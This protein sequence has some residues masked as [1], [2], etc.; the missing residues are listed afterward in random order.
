MTENTVAT[1]INSLQQ[2]NLEREKELA[3]KYWRDENFKITYQGEKLTL[4]EIYDREIEYAKKHFESAKE[5]ANKIP[6]GKFVLFVNS[7]KKGTTHYD[8]INTIDKDRLERMNEAETGDKNTHPDNFQAAN[9]RYSLGFDKNSEKFKE[10]KSYEDIPENLDLTHCVGIVY[11]GSEINVLEEKD[12]TRIK[13]TENVK[14]IMQIA[15]EASI[16]ELGICFGGQLLS[17][18]KGADIQW[19]KDEKGNLVRVVGIKEIELTEEAKN[20]PLVARLE[21]ILVAQN[22]GQEINKESI[23]KVGGII[24]AVSKTGA[25]EIVRFGDKI[26]VL[27]FH[28]EVGLARVDVAMSIGKNP[29]NPEETFKNSIHQIKEAI[30]TGFMEIVVNNL[31]PKK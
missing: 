16:P 17:N 14:H 8:G 21:N 7:A 6:D 2:N 12:G 18:T 15:K 3:N 29:S 1:I 24:L 25:P 4:K 9:M 23:E 31:P 22:H 5:I 20:D 30:M 11:S 28:P 26:Y 27:Q 13:A 19:V 10:F